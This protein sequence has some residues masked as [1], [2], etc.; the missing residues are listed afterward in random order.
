MMEY[1]PPKNI[2]EVIANLNEVID[3]AIETKRV[4]FHLRLA[5]EAFTHP[6]PSSNP[7]APQAHGP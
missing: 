7:L 4:L 5:L 3:W 1:P 2:D 6:T